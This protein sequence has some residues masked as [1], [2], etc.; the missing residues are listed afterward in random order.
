MF[1][2]IFK[3]WKTFRWQYAMQRKEVSFQPCLSLAVGPEDVYLT[4][5]PL[6]PGGAEESL[7]GC[8]SVLRT[9]QVVSL[10]S[11]TRALQG[12]YH[13]YPHWKHEKIEAGK[14]RKILSH[15]RRAELGLDPGT[16]TPEGGCVS[17]HSS[18]SLLAPPA[19]QAAWGSAVKKDWQQQSASVCINVDVI[20]FSLSFKCF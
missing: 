5:R 1:A 20:F 15:Q 18:R 14:S 4:G 12:G 7:L 6:P 11:L 9:V 16:Q 17:P 19:S 3:L 13:F 8:C 10:F 2:I